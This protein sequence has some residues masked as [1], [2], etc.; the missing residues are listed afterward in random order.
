[1]KNVIPF[2]FNQHSVRVIT[3]ENG[4]P[5]FIAKEI[6]EILEYS[7]AE[8][9]TRR[10]DD[11]E[12]QN[13]Q[14]VG[15]GNR[16]VNIINESGLY[17]AIM[18]SQ[19]PAAKVFKKWVT[20]EVLPSIRKTG[21]YASKGNEQPTITKSQQ[22]DLHAIV[23]N[24]ARSSGK[25]VAYYWSRYQNHFKLASYKDTPAHKFE[26]ARQYLLRLEGDGDDSLLSI[27]KSD[28]KTLVIE[29]SKAVIG[30]VGYIGQIPEKPKLDPNAERTYGQ[31]GLRV[32]EYEN[33]R[34][35]EL[36]RHL[37]RKPA[38]VLRYAVFKMA[39]DALGKD[40]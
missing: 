34:I 19:K 32:N 28:L 27:T 24:K 13:R 30:V 3:N 11:D 29:C 39:D 10:L 20:S 21:S 5:W 4:D 17:S 26:E 2:N 9:M 35:E 6:A 18:T 1:M 7:D 25:P 37:N 33:N 12:V 23:A 36:A 14:I 8:A 40:N 38:D 22:G 16:G 15:F 31:L